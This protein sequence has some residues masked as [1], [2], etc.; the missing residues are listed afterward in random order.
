MG[1]SN[2]RV[3][4]IE[5]ILKTITDIFLILIRQ[6]LET[7]SSHTLKNDHP[8]IKPGPYPALEISNGYIYFQM[9]NEIS[10][11][12]LQNLHDKIENVSMVFFS[13]QTFR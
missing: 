4:F 3:R 12:G 13:I 2:V 11:H 8:P 7:I 5:K 9:S 1:F 10:V 6:L